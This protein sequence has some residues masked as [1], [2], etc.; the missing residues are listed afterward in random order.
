MVLYTMYFLRRGTGEIFLDFLQEL[1]AKLENEYSITNFI[2]YI[3]NTRPR[4]ARV[5][6]KEPHC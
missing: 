1:D 6:K 5:L 2:M 3:D 4:I